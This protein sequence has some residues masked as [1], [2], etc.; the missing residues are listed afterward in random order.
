[1][2]ALVVLPALGMS[3]A[4]GSPTGGIGLGSSAL[5]LFLAAVFGLAT[6]AVL[7]ADESIVEDLTRNR[8]RTA[9]EPDARRCRPAASGGS[10]CGT[11]SCGEPS[12]HA[13]TPQ[14]PARAAMR[15][16]WSSTG[17]RSRSSGP[18]PS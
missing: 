17:T 7:A 12:S 1:M 11:A 16:R 18:E 2:L 5:C 13:S 10:G 3:G 14:G 4:L 9:F 8:F 15:R 6:L